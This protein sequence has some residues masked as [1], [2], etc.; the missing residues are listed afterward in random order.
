MVATVASIRDSAQ[1]EI[2]DPFLVN[3]R[4]MKNQQIPN[5]IGDSK[6]LEIRALSC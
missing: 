1:L 6:T 2:K 4:S 5:V 3:I